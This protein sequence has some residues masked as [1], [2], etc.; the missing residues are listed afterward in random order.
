MIHGC[1]LGIKQEDKTKV[2]NVYLGFT[3]Y[4]CGELEENTEV[5]RGQGSDQKFLSKF[6]TVG[7]AKYQQD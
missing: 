2:L 3:W 4:N 1:R 6:I 7:G 5:T